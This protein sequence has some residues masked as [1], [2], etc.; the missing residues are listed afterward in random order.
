[1]KGMKLQDGLDPVR[2][3]VKHAEAA[4]VPVIYWSFPYLLRR[5]RIRFG[6]KRWQ[7]AALAGVSASVVGRAEKGADIRLSTLTRLFNAMGCRP[8]ILPGGALYE[9]DVEDACRDNRCLDW[10]GQVGLFRRVEERR[11]IAGSPAPPQTNERNARLPAP[12]QV[13]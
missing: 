12:A 10:M 13:K 3:A 11:R 1:M 5:T 4:P 6:L 2:D 8:I 7:L 9:M